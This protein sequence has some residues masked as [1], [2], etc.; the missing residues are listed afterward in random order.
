MLNN[1]SP[2]VGSD[3]A[4]ASRGRGRA[5]PGPRRRLAMPRITGVHVPNGCRLRHR[6]APRGQVPTGR[7]SDR[8]SLAHSVRRLRGRTSVVVA[9]LRFC[10]RRLGAVRRTFCSFFCRRPC[11]TQTG[12]AL[13]SRSSSVFVF[14]RYAV[15]VI[16]FVNY[17]CFSSYFSTSLLKYLPF[18]L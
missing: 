8:P 6:R 10:F 7:T 15:L 17:V 18:V 14:F 4:R 16:V 3:P 11:R 13:K 2:H 1:Y 9:E 12:A 5:I